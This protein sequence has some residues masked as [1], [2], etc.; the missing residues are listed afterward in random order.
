MDLRNPQPKVSSSQA[1][2]ADARKRGGRAFCRASTGSPGGR[3]AAS[4]D[5]GKHLQAPPLCRILWTQ[6]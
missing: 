2:R 3:E 1:P 6:T 5:V 4:E